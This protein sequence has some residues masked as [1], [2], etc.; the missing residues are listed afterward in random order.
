MLDVTLGGLELVRRI[1]H[2][3]LEHLATGPGSANRRQA[4]DQERE[5]R[6][7]QG[8]GRL[9]IALNETVDARRRVALL[10]P[11]QTRKFAERSTAD[12]RRAERNRPIAPPIRAMFRRGN[13]DIEPRGENRLDL[14]IEHEHAITRPRGGGVGL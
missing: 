7:A 4:S 6:H 3:E 13:R 12:H 5:D 2:L 8:A 14:G 9:R 10:E 11:T 1:G